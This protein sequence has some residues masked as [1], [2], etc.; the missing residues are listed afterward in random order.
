M[1]DIRFERQFRTPYSE[2]YYIMQGAA[3]SGPTRLGAVDLHFCSTQV[4][5][6]L[7]L[8]ERELEATALERLIEQIDE[9]L[10]LSADTP[11]E[12]FLVSVYVGRDVGFYSDEALSGEESEEKS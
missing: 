8:F 7:I 12:D 11:R 3:Q 10:V 4:H 6:T 1:D 2:S 5:G 9:D